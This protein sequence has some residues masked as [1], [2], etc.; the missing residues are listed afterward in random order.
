M[1]REPRSPDT[2]ELD[3]GSG[4][5]YQLG[6][7]QDG[8]VSKGWS[9]RGC[10][11]LG[12]PSELTPVCEVRSFLPHSCR[13]GGLRVDFA[14][15]QAFL[16]R[17]QRTLLSSGMSLGFPGQRSPVS[18]LK[19]QQLLSTTQPAPMLSPLTLTI[20]PLITFYY[21]PPLQVWKTKALTFKVL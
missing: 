2:D 10:S 14:H 8:T 1:D 6:S 20:T 13:E 9:S 18:P 3:T 11:G 21:V 17:T 19:A 12:V 4:L 5:S 16:L 15:Q 7:A